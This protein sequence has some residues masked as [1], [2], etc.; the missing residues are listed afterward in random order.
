LFKTETGVGLKKYLIESRLETGRELLESSLLTVK[1]ITVRVGY[2]HVSHFVRD[3]KRTYQSTPAQY[4]RE[5][6]D[7]K[8]PTDEC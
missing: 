8:Y 2:S 7:G 5:H 3:F 4:R 1:E 6:L